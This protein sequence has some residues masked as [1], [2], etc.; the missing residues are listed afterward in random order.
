MSVALILLA[1][2]ASMV[3][4]QTVPRGSA[5]ILD[6]VVQTAE[7]SDAVELSGGAGT[8]LLLKHD[9]R[10]LFVGITTS[11]PMIADVCTIRNDTIRVLH[12]SASLGSASYA[13]VSDSARMRIADFTWALRDGT[14]AALSAVARQDHYQQFGWLATTIGMAAQSREWR[15]RLGD[16]GDS[17]RIAVTLLSFGAGGMAAWPATVTDQCLDRSFAMG[18]APAV[19]RFAPLTWM[20]LELAPA[21]R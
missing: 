14:E 6:G 20:T 3:T 5:P 2:M 21:S 9:G 7:W 13:G 12:S 8:R 17:P 16:L 4:A 1:T 19:A 10:D 18:T 11:G 15:I